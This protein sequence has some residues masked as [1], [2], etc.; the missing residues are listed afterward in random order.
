M[1][2][3]CYYPIVILLRI[4][5]GLYN[6]FEVHGREN[7]PQE[8]A[9]IVVSNHTSYLDPTILGAAVKGRRLYYLAKE[10]LFRVPFL[11]AFIKHH[12]LPVGRGRAIPSAIKKALAT[13]AS[14]GAIALFP[15]GGRARGGDGTETEFQKGIDLI[16]RRSG[17]AILPVYIEGAE[18]SWPA[19][20]KFIKPAKIRVIIGKPF[21]YEKDCAEAGASCV[22]LEKIKDLS[23]WR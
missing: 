20:G 1:L 9:L 6:R 3:F 14:G 22:S 18:R 5:F 17:A 19:G 8:G 16:A 11:G 7:I 10:E 13:L 12:S 2:S 21:S 15:G 23:Q 4:I